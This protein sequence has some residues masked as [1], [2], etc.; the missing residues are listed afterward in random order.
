MDL[1][2][3]IKSQFP[4]LTV[5]LLSVL[6]GLTFSDLV[7]I[8]RARMTLWPLDLGSLRTWAQLAAMASCAFSVWII[9]AHLAISRF[10]I[11]AFADSVIVFVIPP[12][13]LIGNSLVGQAA[14]WPWF[15]FASFYLLVSLLTWLWQ[16]RVAAAETELAAFARLSRPTGPLSVLYIGIPFYAA[17]GWADAHG[18]FSPLAEV[19]IAAAATPAAFLTAWIFMR[20]WHRAILATRVSGA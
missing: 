9:F 8:A 7:E 15:C 19:L 4:V 18:F 2:D 3:R 13:I 10:R 6:I 17:A 1:E 12:A 5:T 11:P 14:I 20:E 16:V